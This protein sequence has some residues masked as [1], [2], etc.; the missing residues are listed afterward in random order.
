MLADFNDY[1]IP[2]NQ[3]LPGANIA[4]RDYPARGL[5]APVCSIKVQLD[6]YG[7]FTLLAALHTSEAQTHQTAW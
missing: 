7:F 4:Q 3:L 6:L 5:V 1:R 2:D